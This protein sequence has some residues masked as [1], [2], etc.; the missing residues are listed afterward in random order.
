M[1]IDENSHFYTL[2]GQLDIL[3]NNNA[4]FTVF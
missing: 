1:L 4:I 2:N 3:G